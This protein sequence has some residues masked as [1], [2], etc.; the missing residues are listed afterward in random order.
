MTITGINFSATPGITTIRFG[1]LTAGSVQCTTTQ[2]AAIAPAGSSH[3]PVT[4]IVSGL[5]SGA[6]QFSYIPVVTSLTPSKGSEAGGTTVVINGA[7]LSPSEFATYPTVAFGAN[8]SPSL[9]NCPTPHTCTVAS[10]AGNGVVDVLVTVDGQ[11]SRPSAADKFTYTPA[12]NSPGWTHW[13][14]DTL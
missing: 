1:A 9:P 8:P 12:N 7:G 3:V 5:T 4:V 13:N 14:T 6:Y 10:P 11:T 2:C